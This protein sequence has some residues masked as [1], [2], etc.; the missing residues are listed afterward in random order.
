MG[1]HLTNAAREARRRALTDGF[2][3]G[4][5][6]TQ[7]ADQLGLAPHVLD[8]WMMR[9]GL[10]PR[11]EPVAP[12]RSTLIAG[13]RTVRAYPTAAGWLVDC[14]P[15]GRRFT[16]PDGRRACRLADAHVRLHQRMPPPA[17]Q[18]A[19]TKPRKQHPAGPV[20]HAERRRLLE[21]GAQIADIAKQLGLT[22]RAVHH[23]RA[24]YAP[25]VP[26]PPPPWQ[27][28]AMEAQERFARSESPETVAAA[29]EI[30]VPSLA[31][32]CARHGIGTAPAT[33][34]AWCGCGLRF[35]GTQAQIV[36]AASVHWM[37]T[38]CRWQL[39][40]TPIERTTS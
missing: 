34:E 2:A 13:S 27:A 24:K 10:E 1:G 8:M 17:P 9:N 32:L 37:A 3:A 36:Y 28:R 22:P 14:G 4:L 26:L 18:P 5:S 25:D 39:H 31:N 33:T 38:C 11:P 20:D 16:R 29:L 15:C 19:P 40:Q 12:V 6:L 35:A 30:T 21:S 23:W 7:I